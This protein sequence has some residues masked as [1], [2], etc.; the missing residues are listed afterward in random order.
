[1]RVGR[2]TSLQKL[3]CVVLS[4]AVCGASALA[5]TGTV[6]DTDGRPLE[7]ARVCYFQ[8]ETNI[9]QGCAN[10]S[11]TGTFLLPDS[12]HMMLRASAEG[13][14][15]ETVPALGHQAIVLKR[16]PTLTV[17][18]LDDSNGEPIERG[19]VFVIYSS[20]TMKGPFP[21]NRA[22]VKISRLLQPGDVRVIG[23]A[24]GYEE[25]KPQ[26]VTLEPGEQSEVSLRPR[27]KPDSKKAD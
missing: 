23:K 25:S 17:R 19:E 15:P 5:V 13:Y 16:S 7:Q 20:A 9:E 22:G 6:T 12:R 3:L 24:D 8:T 11:K 10:P 27:P 4:L 21:T 18:L 26:S 2:L 1:M 14:Y